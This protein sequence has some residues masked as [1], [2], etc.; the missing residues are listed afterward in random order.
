MNEA[1]VLSAI[2]K[3]IEMADMLAN[4]DPEV[5]PLT[6]AEWIALRTLRSKYHRKLYNESL[7]IGV[8]DGTP[9]WSE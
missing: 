4:D 2:N 7:W 8:P 6:H 9:E 3:A 1:L 5:Q